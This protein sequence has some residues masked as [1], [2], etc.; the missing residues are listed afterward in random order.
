MTSAEKLCELI[1]LDKG[2]FEITERTG[3]YVVESCFVMNREPFL[4]DGCSDDR[5]LCEVI[6]MLEGGVVCLM[7]EIE[8]ITRFKE[9]FYEDADYQGSNTDK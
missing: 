3:F 7:K 8:M 1:G 2:T 6:S 5:V 4:Q 9:T